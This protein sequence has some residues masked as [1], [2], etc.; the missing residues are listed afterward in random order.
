MTYASEL[1]DPSLLAYATPAEREELARLAG[2]PPIWRPHPK[3]Y[4]QQMAFASTAD[5]VGFG[6][7]AGGGKT[8]LIIGKA[9][10]QHRRVAVFRKNGTEHT[11]F[12]DRLSE[13]IGSRDGLNGSTGIWRDVGP[14]QVQLELCS[15]PNPGDEGKYRGRPHDLKAFDEVTEIPEYQVSFVM[16]WLR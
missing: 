7:A 12:V 15:L 16:T 14:R 4:P 2:P 3:N 8:D 11:A 10:L 13:I 6:G 5:V 9:L 1:L